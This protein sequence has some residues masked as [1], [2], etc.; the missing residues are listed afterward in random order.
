MAEWQHKV[1]VYETRGR[2]SSNEYPVKSTRGIGT[3][4]VN[5]VQSNKEMM[6]LEEWL[7]YQSKD[8]WELFKFHPVGACVFRRLV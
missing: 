7:D 5:S 3:V 1:R 6:D 4:G 8:G 2:F